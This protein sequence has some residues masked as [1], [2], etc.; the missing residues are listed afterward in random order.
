MDDFWG[1][2]MIFRRGMVNFPGGTGQF[3]QS[4]ME[5]INAIKCS[6]YAMWTGKHFLLGKEDK[7]IRADWCARMTEGSHPNPYEGPEFLIP[8]LSGLLPEMLESQVLV[9]GCNGDSF[10]NQV[11]RVHFDPQ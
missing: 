10:V 6:S 2:W 8:P 4:I 1:K 7:A 9:Q 5:L 11:H 3:F